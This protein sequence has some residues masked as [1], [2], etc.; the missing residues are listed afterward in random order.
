MLALHS[1]LDHTLFSRF[2]AF[3]MAR[4][5]SG[6]T[7]THHTNVAIKVLRFLPNILPTIHSTHP[8]HGDLLQWL[9]SLKTSCYQVGQSCSVLDS[10]LHT[11]CWCGI[12]CCR[13]CSH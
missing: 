10:L 13:C 12:W 11:V 7:L 2:T 5:T 9:S 3:L 1:Y 4:K 8:N 6:T